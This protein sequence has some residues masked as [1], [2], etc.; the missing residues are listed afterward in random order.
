MDAGATRIRERM[1]KELVE[2]IKKEEE[3]KAKRIEERMRIEADETKRQLIEA[4]EAL[5]S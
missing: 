5:K 3:E 4:E 2:M 1:L